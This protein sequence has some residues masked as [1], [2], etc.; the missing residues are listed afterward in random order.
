VTLIGTDGND[1]LV[2]SSGADSLDGGLGRDT[3]SGG[4]GDDTYI[5]DRARDLVIEYPDEGNDTI[6]SSV[7]YVLLR[8]SRISFSP[9]PRRLAA[10][11]TSST[12]S[13]RGA[14]RRTCSTAA[15]EPTC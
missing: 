4:L 14:L 12:T 13:L 2:G 3:L 6:R 1:I 8:T 11:A 15:P 5:V 7:S 9:A 10:P